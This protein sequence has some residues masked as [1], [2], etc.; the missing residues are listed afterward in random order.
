MDLRY[1]DSD[2]HFRS[3]LRAWLAEAVPAHGPG[4][5]RHDWDARRAYDTSW[6]RKLFEAGY[7]GINWPKEYGGRGASL[8]EELVYYEELSRARAPNVAMNFVGVRHGGPTLIAEGTDEQKAAHLPR[9]LRGEEVWCQGFSEPTAG[10]D[11]AALRTSAVLDGDHYVVNGQKIWT[12]F[13]HCADYCELLVRTGS[14]SKH[15]GISWLIMPMDLEGIEIRPLPTLL[16][17][18]DFSEMFLEDVRIPVGNRVGK[19]NDGWRV[20]N[21]TLSFERGTAWAADVIQLQRMLEGIAELAQSIERQ[22]ASAWDDQALRREIGHLSAEVES[23]WSM[24]KLQVSELAQSGVPGLGGSVIKLAFTELN[25]RIFE[26]GT[27]LLGRAGLARD[28]VEGLADL[29]IVDRYLSTLSLT[30]AA[31]SS[32]I[33]RNIISERMLGMPKEPRIR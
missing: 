17:E 25:Q 21:V 9:I 18:S 29:G 5:S 24:V 14:D 10:S 19:E 32:Q 31:G 7:A 15:R 3:D 2:Q 30:I 12:S 26:L 28:P 6:Q 27:R 11:L 16:G 20:T 23:V 33:Q 4:P 8:M 22:G 1:S 13:A